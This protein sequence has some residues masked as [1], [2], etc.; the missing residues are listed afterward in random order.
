MNILIAGH[1]VVDHIF[2][3][4]E[5]NVLPG[6]IYY[7]A[8][9]FNSVCNNEDQLY[10][11]T[12]IDDKDFT[13]FQE[14]YEKFDLSYVNKFEGLPHVSFYEN[15]H[16]QRNKD[17]HKF[18]SSLSYS[19]I[20]DW[21]KF[22]GI[23]INMITGFELSADDFVEIRKLY[24][25]KIYVDIHTLARN[26]DKHNHRYYRKIPE[27]EKYLSNVNYVQVNE[28][29]LLSITPYNDIKKITGTV[30]K[31]GVEILILTKGKNGVEVFLNDG[32]QI[33]LDSEKVNSVNKLGCGDVFGAVFFNYLLRNDNVEDALKKA[34]Y[35]A[36]L[37]TTYSNT[38]EMMNLRYDFFKRYS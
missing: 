38:K 9:G 5:E 11:L 2:R 20:N 4:N 29:E 31:L 33:Q 28:N 1:S 16:V 23:Y 24:T 30:F 17:Y 6:G 25:G 18:I 36:A 26:L 19:K 27:Y 37:I 22:D 13:R 3:N 14:V 7:S 10:L 35:A 8:L 21:K 34:N 12:S 15:G 32:K